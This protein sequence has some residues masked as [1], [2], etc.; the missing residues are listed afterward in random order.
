MLYL[1]EQLRQFLKLDESKTFF[2]VIKGKQV[3]QVA[4]NLNTLEQLF[5]E[6]RDADGEIIGVYSAFTEMVNSGRTFTFKG[7]TKTKREGQPI[8]LFEEGDFYGSWTVKIDKDGLTL[9]ADPM[10]E[11][12]NLVEDFGTAII[13]LNDES[14]EKFAEAILPMVIEATRQQMFG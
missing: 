3:Q 14:K 6:G 5:K 12:T 11:D 4:I 9:I 7:V 13:G 8:F 1:E 2:T 10:K